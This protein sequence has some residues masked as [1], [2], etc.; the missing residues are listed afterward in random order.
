MGRY[1]SIFPFLPA[2]MSYEQALTQWL[3]GVI[4]PRSQ[5]D[6]SIE[7]RVEYAGGE[8]AVR[9]IKELRNDG[10]HNG[11][12]SQ[13]L[14]TIKFAD[15]EYMME[16]YHP[17]ESTQG[18]VYNTPDKRQATRVARV[19]KPSPWR[20]HYELRLYPNYEIDL[21]FMM[22]SLLQR[23]HHHG[24]LAY[25]TIKGKGGGRNL[26]PLFL[27]GFSPTTNSETGQNDRDVGATLLLELEAYL[28]LPLRFVP[29]FRSY[30]QE[31]AVSGTS[32]GDLPTTIEGP[33]VLVPP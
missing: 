6:R 1:E 28:P 3:K 10:S 9:A 31:I 23:F 26:F 29:T 32:P 14:I 5:E 11:K 12:S 20:V 7:T 16:R 33:T 25:L 24:G 15:C 27:R 30:I 17:P 13:P 22:F 4:V 2:F 8:K 18:Y 19:S 21:R